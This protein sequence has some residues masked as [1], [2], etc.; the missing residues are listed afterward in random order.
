MGYIAGV[1]REQQVLFPETLDEYVTAD[2]AV[3]FIDAFVTR[4]D[5]RVLGFARTT[6]AQT[7]RPGYDPGDLLRL[8]VYGYMNRVRS[9]RAL[10]REAQRNVEVMWLLGKRHPDHKTI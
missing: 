2:N 1:D 4:L 7:G 8:Y 10:E 5:L 6:P 9:S 3:R